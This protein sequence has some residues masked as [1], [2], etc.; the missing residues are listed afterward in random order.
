MKWLYLI[1]ASS[2]CR[3]AHGHSLRHRNQKTAGKHRAY[4]QKRGHHRRRPT[5]AAHGCNQRAGATDWKPLHA[6]WAQEIHRRSDHYYFHRQ[7]QMR[8]YP[9]TYGKL[10]AEY[11]RQAVDLQRRQADRSFDAENPT[12]TAILSQMISRA[13]AQFVIAV[14]K[15]EKVVSKVTVERTCLI[16]VSSGGTYRRCARRGSPQNVAC[17]DG[18]A[19]P[20]LPIEALTLQIR[21]LC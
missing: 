21:H 8:Q 11:I 15:D 7:N 4:G 19:R 14:L 6:G 18:A 1:G 20:Y 13:H 5:K 2:S 17:S 16:R 3:S 12:D 9:E 10:G